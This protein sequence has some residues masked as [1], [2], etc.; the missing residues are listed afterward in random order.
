MEIT[1]TQTTYYSVDVSSDEDRKSLAK[2][3][4]VTPKKLDLLIEE[5]ELLD[6]DRYDKVIKWVNDQNG[7]WNIT[8]EDNIEDVEVHA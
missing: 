1:F 6:D 3:L 5:G 2:A 8:D 4:G 7:A